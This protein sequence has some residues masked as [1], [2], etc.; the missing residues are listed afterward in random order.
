MIFFYCRS[1]WARRRSLVPKEDSVAWHLPRGISCSRVIVLRP[2]F[3]LFLVRGNSIGY[4]TL[5]FNLPE[6]KNSHVPFCSTVL[7]SQQCHQV[8]KSSSRQA[9][10]LGRAAAVTEGITEREHK[11]IE[12]EREREHVNGDAVWRPLGPP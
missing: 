7:P 4:S 8:R 6:K 12:S 5:M 2:P 9:A 1:A 3:V 11:Q 10:P